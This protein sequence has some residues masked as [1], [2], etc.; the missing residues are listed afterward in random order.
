MG[1]GSASSDVNDGAIYWSTVDNVTDLSPEELVPFPRCPRV[2]S[3]PADMR[4]YTPF[5]QK[6]SRGWMQKEGT[7]F[8][9]RAVPGPKRKNRKKGWKLPHLKRSK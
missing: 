2:N 8:S 1:V 9:A 7:F 3:P 5:E 6:A 4:P